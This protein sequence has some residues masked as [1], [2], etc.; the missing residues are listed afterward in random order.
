MSLD[1]I[2]KIAYKTDTKSLTDSKR[3]LQDIIDTAGKANKSLAGVMGGA[4]GGAKGTFGAIPG[5]S[6]EAK[7]SKLLLKDKEALKSFGREGESVARMFRDTLNKEL[8]QL[9]QK[10]DASAK[11]MVLARQRLEEYRKEAGRVKSMGGDAT[12][13][14]M[15]VD[16]AQ[17]E[18]FR[19][20]EHN[21]AA[22]KARDDLAGKGAAGAS[23]ELGLSTLVTLLRRSAPF[24]VLQGAQR[25][26]N[27]LD[28]GLLQG[29][30]ARQAS[31]S[32][33][34]D[35]EIIRA[36]AVGQ[37]QAASAL[38]GGMDEA[39][40]RSRA[41][42]R[43][44]D[45]IE[46]QIKQKTEQAD[47]EGNAFRLTMKNIGTPWKFLTDDFQKQMDA[48]KIRATQVQNSARDETIKEMAE[49]ERAANPVAEAYQQRLKGEALNWVNFD[50]TM[51]YSN[52]AK[53]VYASAPGVKLDPSEM[54]GLL[55]SMVQT[56]G[57]SA[58]AQKGNVWSAIRAGMDHGTAANIAAMGSI[59]GNLLGMTAGIAD[60]AVRAA[61][62]SGI[63]GMVNDPNSQASMAGLTQMAMGGIDY[64]ANTADQRR[65]MQQNLSALQ[66]I[67]NLSSG[68]TPWQ[69][70]VNL[71][72]AV[73]VLG[74]TG[75]IYSQQKLS[76]IPIST[77]ESIL[78]SGDPKSHIPS[79]WGSQIT[80]EVLRQYAGKLYSTTMA[81][82]ADQGG[83]DSQS[84]IARQIK[85]DFRGNIQEW[86]KYQQKRFG[87]DAKGFHR[88]L[89]EAG[90]LLSEI[91]SAGWGSDEEASARLRVLAGEKVRPGKRGAG[92]H[93][94]GT[95]AANAAESMLQNVNALVSTMMTT[96]KSMD[97]L[98]Q[99]QVKAMKDWV[100]A[101]QR[102]VLEMRGVGEVANKGIRAPNLTIR[103]PTR[104]Q[105]YDRNAGFGEE[106]PENFVLK[107]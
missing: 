14:N 82:W 12:I 92:G 95:L 48:G 44:R 105:N 65:T 107:R 27:Y 33:H 24:L 63:A 84:R 15:N 57:R 101:T 104:G 53:G 69:Q 79:S 49:K 58:L 87:K 76:T 35:P 71:S 5:I 4:A 96:V 9:N 40:F 55:T 32:M 6:Q 94:G 90:G 64:T 80:P 102:G 10:I 78:R 73:S 72:N 62:G 54:M 22:R 98:T 103:A 106:V 7:L 81:Q 89:D 67:N 42:F 18:F 21:A 66:G 61:L 3:L 100:E 25:G 34:L 2:L 60:P 46:E 47:W 59:Q 88:M 77:I 39:F 41:A 29:Y 70:T 37:F 56:G 19:A 31:A 51:G 50:R 93:G 23:S 28:T 86:V 16:R 43:Q 83:Q 68:R 20:T 17:G 8:D 1:K 99:Q 30:S 36:Q 75:T 45:Q 38:G 97:G 85:G 52:A 74:S 26:F 13:E 11:R 91:D